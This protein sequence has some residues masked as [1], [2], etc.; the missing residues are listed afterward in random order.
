MVPVSL[1]RNGCKLRAYEAKQAAFAEL[2]GHG[3]YV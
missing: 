3:L 2:S 1:H